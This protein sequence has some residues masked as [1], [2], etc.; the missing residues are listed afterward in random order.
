MIMSAHIL[1]RICPSVKVLL[2][3]A[4]FI[5]VI[6]FLEEGNGFVTWF[7]AH[8]A[9]GITTDLFWS[10]NAAAL[11]ITILIVALSLSWPSAASDGISFGWI[12]FL[13]GANAVLHV[14]GAMSDRAYMPGLV[15]AV[16]L[17][18]PFYLLLVRALIK[19]RR[20]QGY[21]LCVAGIAGAAPMLMHGYLIIFRGDRL[22]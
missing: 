15:S 6:H 17:Y 20:I 12:S 14:V 19:A 1:G 10:V 13:F 11:V 7:N 2:A 16:L 9:R 5:F 21:A 3:T 4:P 8:V 18:I 22:F